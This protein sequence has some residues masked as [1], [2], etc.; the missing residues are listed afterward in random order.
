MDKKLLLPIA[1]CLLL[2]GCGS[3][4]QLKAHIADYTLVCV[5][6]TNIMYVQFPTGVSPLYTP[7]GTLVNCK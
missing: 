4:N 7:N 3:W 6:E 5:T 2:T 1:A